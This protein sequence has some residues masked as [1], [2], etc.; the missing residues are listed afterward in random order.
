MTNGEEI[1]N[2]DRR[3]QRI[4][5]KSRLVHDIDSALDLQNYGRFDIPE[6]EKKIIGVI[7]D[8]NSTEEIYFT[9]NPKNVLNVGLV[10][11]RNIIRGPIGLKNA[12]SKAKT[13]TDHFF[14]FITHEILADVLHHTNKKIDSLLA[15]L[16]ADFNKNFKY[17][18][19][20]KVNEMELKAFIGLFLYRG[21]YKLNTVEIRKLF[22]DSYG[23][24]MF[25][26]E[27][28]ATVLHLFYTIYPLMMKVPMLK[29]GKRT[30]LLRFM[31][32]LKNSIINA[33]WS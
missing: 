21:L 9:N 23:P 16:P 31:S 11:G 15:K 19:V 6:T 4:L 14:L 24:P 27:C 33:C 17:S 10:Y 7:K 5:T 20:N 22:S 30:G 12:A 18:F 2:A 3:I 25:S 26:A 32:F 13:E 1:E 8:K 29:D 28:L